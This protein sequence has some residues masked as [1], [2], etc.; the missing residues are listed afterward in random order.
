MEKMM[1]ELRGIPE[2]VLRKY[3]EKLGGQ[4]Q[5]DG[6]FCG[7]GWKA[8]LTLLEDQQYKTLTFCCVKVEFEGDSQ[9]LAEVWPRFELKTLRPGG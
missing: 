6:W 4:Y 9:A 3:L 1:R 2:W 8:R 5:P 7:A